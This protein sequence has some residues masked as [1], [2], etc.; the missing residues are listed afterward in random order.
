MPERPTNA[1]ALSMATT[2][3][4]VYGRFSFTGATRMPD[5]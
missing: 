4:E 2:M 5:W 3:T 1:Q